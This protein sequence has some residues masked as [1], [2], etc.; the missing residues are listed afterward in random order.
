M[1]IAILTGSIREKRQSHKA[2]YYVTKALRERGIETDLIDLA[3]TPLPMYGVEEAA[4]VQLKENVANISS[5]LDD[6]DALIFVTPEY[7][8][9]I[10]GVLKNALDHF[11]SEFRKKPIGVIAASGGKMAGINASTQLQHVILSMGAYPIPLKLLIPEIHNAIDDSFEPQ[12]GQVVRSTEKFL[13]EFLWF[14]GALYQQHAKY[15]ALGV[16]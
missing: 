9:S 11:W 12:N 13:N 8:G 10:S 4:D 15:K 14:A 2:A 7:H 5:R 16:A 6:A 1:K 3:E